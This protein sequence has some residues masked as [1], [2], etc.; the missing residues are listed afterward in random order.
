MLL[1]P[2]LLSLLLLLLLLLLSLLLL[3]L[4]FLLLSLLLLVVVVVVIVVVVV[5]CRDGRG[6]VGCGMVGTEERLDPDAVGLKPP[7]CDGAPRPPCC[8]RFVLLVVE[9][10]AHAASDK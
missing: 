4:L 8:S 2:L 7:A 3:L 6:L 10:F 9:R 5:V 1:L